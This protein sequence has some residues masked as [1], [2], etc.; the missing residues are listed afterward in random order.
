MLTPPK[1]GNVVKEF[2]IGNTTI[3]ICDDYYRDKT[4]EDIEKILMNISQMAYNFL[5]ASGNSS[6]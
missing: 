3:K 1:Q 5:S 6:K 2:M 4:P